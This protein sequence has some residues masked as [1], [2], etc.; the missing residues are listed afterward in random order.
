MKSFIYN[1]YCLILVLIL[2]SYS[3]SAQND[4]SSVPKKGSLKI[5]C[6]GKLD[7]LV[8]LQKRISEE[9]QTTPGY[10]VQLFFGTERKKANEIKAGFLQKHNEI[11]SYVLYQQPNYKVRVGDF[12]TRLEAYKLLQELTIEFPSAF[13]VSDEIILPE[14]E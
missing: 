2:Y 12:R 7:S 14:L 1:F 4:S 10:R 3:S 9:K 11:S 13:I 6:D 8:Q 5:I